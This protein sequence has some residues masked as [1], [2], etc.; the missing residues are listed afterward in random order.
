MSKY[1]YRASVEPPARANANGSFNVIRLGAIP[2]SAM[3]PTA[4]PARYI[5][6]GVV[7]TPLEMPCPAGDCGGPVMYPID[8]VPGAGNTNGVRQPE[9]VGPAPVWTVPNPYPVPTSPAPSPTVGVSPSQTAPSLTSPGTVLSTTGSAPSGWAPDTPYSVGQSLV[10]VQGNLQEVTTA[11]VSGSTPPAFNENA[12]GTTG[13]NGV[14][15]TNQGTSGTAGVGSIT[16]WLSQET[17]IT[18]FPNWGILAAAAVA[19]FAMT[20]KSGRR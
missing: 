17:I 18:G 10:D 6:G 19:V 13:D 12:G 4:G 14:T 16:S 2:V 20:G 7:T 8:Y 3:K 1:V 15:W 11:G 5:G 9:P